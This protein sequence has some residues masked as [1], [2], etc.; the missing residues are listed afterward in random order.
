[1]SV[2]EDET[3]DDLTKF[4]RKIIQKK[5]GFRFAIDAVLLANFL[6]IKKKSIMIDIGTGTG[7]MPLLLVDNPKIEKIYGIEIQ[8]EIAKMAKRTVNINDLGEK[9]EIVKEDFNNI[10]FN[11]KVDIIVTNPPYIKKENGKIST[12][13]IK[14]ISRHELKLNLEQLV[15]KSKKTLKSGG[16]FNII[17]R[18]NR[19]Q[20]L[21]SM[22]HENKFYIKRLRFI[23]SK[24][25]KNSNLFMI[26]AIKDRVSELEILPAL[27]L[28]NE[29]GNYTEEVL[30]YY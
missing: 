10:N 22:L 11:F 3:L 30:E 25:S 20:E 24:P 18:T 12:N 23:H 9:I 29:E 26:E 1:M 28:F 15:L 6:N 13:S 8:E 5:D 17:Y 14:A 16:S 7:I 2:L 19:F 27:Y 4:N 21:A